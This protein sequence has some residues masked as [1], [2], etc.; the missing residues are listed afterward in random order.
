MFS[1]CFLYKIHV[2]CMTRSKKSFVYVMKCVAIWLQAQRNATH[3][4]CNNN[5]TLAFVV[6][7][8]CFIFFAFL[9]ASSAAFVRSFKCVSPKIYLFSLL[10]TLS[11]ALLRLK[12]P[13]IYLSHCYFLSSFALCRLSLVWACWVYQFYTFFCSFNNLCYSNSAP[14]LFPTTFTFLY[15]FFCLLDFIY[16]AVWFEVVLIK[17][18]LSV[19]LHRSTTFMCIFKI[20]FKIKITGAHAHR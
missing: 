18:N 1:F 8:D 12:S 9:F 19:L 17:G 11:P 20:Q 6:A 3:L 14:P 15:C 2:K 16:L 7:C 4:Q 13:L 5:T 10:Q